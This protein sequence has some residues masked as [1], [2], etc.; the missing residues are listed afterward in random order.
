LTSNNFK[1]GIFTSAKKIEEKSREKAA[2]QT[3]QFW[4]DRESTHCKLTLFQ[5][6]PQINGLGKRKRGLKGW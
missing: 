4:F 6:I 2:K 5:I 3:E 1:N